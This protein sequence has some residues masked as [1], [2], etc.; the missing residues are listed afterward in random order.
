MVEPQKQCIGNAAM[1]LPEL[2]ITPQ[3][4]AAVS[5]LA[6]AGL[7]VGAIYMLCGVAW[8][9]LAGAVVLLLFGAVLLRGLIN[10]G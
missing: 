6:S 7:I 3:H 9:M 1:R 4:L 5:L 2:K 8:A 10:V